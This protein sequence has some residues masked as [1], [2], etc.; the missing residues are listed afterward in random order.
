MIVN[1]NSS[2]RLSSLTNIHAAMVCRALRATDWGHSS[3]GE[4]VKDTI[5]VGLLRTFSFSY[6]RRQGNCANHAL[7]KKAIVS[8][9]LLVWIEH[10]P[11]DVSP[12]VIYNLPFA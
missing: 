5:S 11:P 8:F 7:A 1:N 12:F 9:L 10:V 3:I 2:H 4:F 6:I